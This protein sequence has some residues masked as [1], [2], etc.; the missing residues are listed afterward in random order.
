METLTR[1][2]KLKKYSSIVYIYIRARSRDVGTGTVQST[3]T[4]TQLLCCLL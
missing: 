2:E 1:N 3:G 4:S